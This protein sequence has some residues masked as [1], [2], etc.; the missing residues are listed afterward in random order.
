MFLGLFQVPDPGKGVMAA[1]DPGRDAYSTDAEFGLMPR[2][3]VRR[4]FDA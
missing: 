2:K 3:T 4:R 1:L